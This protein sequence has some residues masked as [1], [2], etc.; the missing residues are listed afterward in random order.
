MDLPSDGAPCV[1]EAAFAENRRGV[2]GRARR[3]RRARSAV[4]RGLEVTEKVVVPEGHRDQEQGV[5]DCPYERPGSRR[6]IAQ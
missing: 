2:R 5:D 4:P 1:S 3:A 6:L